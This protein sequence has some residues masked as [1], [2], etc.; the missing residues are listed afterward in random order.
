MS[1]WLLREIGT[2]RVVA[3]RVRRADDW[4]TRTVGFLPRTSIDADEGLWFA[5][6]RS[7]H[8]LGMRVALDVLFLDGEGRVVRIAS[9]VRPGRWHVGE[10]RA[11]AVAEFA[12]GFA[13]ANG[14]AIGDVLALERAPAELSG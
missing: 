10:H 5:R 12:A 11:A 13:A 4:L 8:T 6:C 2:G 7:I 14:I 1:T 3:T 9:G